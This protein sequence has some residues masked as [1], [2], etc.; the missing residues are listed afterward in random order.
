MEPNEALGIAAP[1][2]AV[3]SAQPEGYGEFVLVMNSTPFDTNLGA[4]IAPFGDRLRAD[5][6]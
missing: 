2:A 5:S 3:R 6:S 4:R 1:V